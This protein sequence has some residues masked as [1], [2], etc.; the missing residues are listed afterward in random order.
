V[1]D[2]TV[3]SSR[4]ETPAMEAG[5]SDHVWSVHELITLWLTKVLAAY[6]RRTIDEIETF[7]I[8]SSV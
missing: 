8:A 6:C 2:V 5:L 7:K 4:A 1:T 3:E